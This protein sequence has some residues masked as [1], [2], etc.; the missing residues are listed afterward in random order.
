MQSNIQLCCAQY[1]VWAGNWDLQVCDGKQ[2]DSLSHTSPA[3]NTHTH[4]PADEERMNI[5]AETVDTKH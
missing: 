2:H 1:A 5:T 3:V 4:P